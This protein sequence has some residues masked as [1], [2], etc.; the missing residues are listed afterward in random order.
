MPVPHAQPCCR[1]ATVKLV[2]CLDEQRVEIHI[3]TETG[4]TV[5]GNR[6]R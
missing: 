5:A 4:E 6:E 1:A 2:A 3:A